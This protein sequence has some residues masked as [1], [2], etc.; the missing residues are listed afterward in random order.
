MPTRDHTSA[1]PALLSARPALISAGLGAALV[2]AA[3]IIPRARH[4]DVRVHWPPLHADWMPRFGTGTVVAILVGIALW[5]LF[6]PL[7]RRLSWPQLMIATYAAT[8]AWIMALAYTDGPE[9]LRSVFD[10]GGEYVYDAQRVKSIPDMLRTFTDH[11][12]MDSA[13]HWHTHVAGHPPGALLYFVL[14]DR[15]GVT[16]H[17]WIGIITVTIG[18]TAVSAA[19]LTLCALGGEDLAQRAAPW[20]VLA[21]TAVWMGVSGDAMFTAVAAWGV[22]FLALAGARYRP[23]YA[24]AG[25]VLLGL[26]VYLSYGLPILGLIALAV[27]WLTG[28]W[29]VLP[30]AIGG[31]LIVAAAFTFAGFSWWEAYPILVDRYYDGIAS[32]RS[33]SYWVWGDIAAWTFTVGLATWAA[34]P[35]IPAALRRRDPLAVLATAAMACILVA[36][37]SGMS[38]AEVERIWLPF[39]LWIVVL[40]ALLPTRW[41]RPL[42]A[43]QVVLAVLVQT[44]V[45][46]RW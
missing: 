15:L 6:P 17:L 45:L 14:I 2:A 44:L 20:L 21:P 5:T 30:W 33:Y 19:V 28:C 10:R 46:T 4:D 39:S 23:A 9:G 37:L 32:E 25:G 35:S 3:I 29:K 26:C 12:P 42:L 8:W 31:A 13:H 24:V 41:Q 38:K 16:S 7:A 43:S 34:F 11:I 22:C 1:R 18:A 27:V 36:T 40:P